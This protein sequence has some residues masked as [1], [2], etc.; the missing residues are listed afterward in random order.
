MD[1]GQLP[2][3]QDNSTTT[4]T[5]SRQRHQQHNGECDKQPIPGVETRIVA[6]AN[7]CTTCIFTWLKR[8]IFEMPPM[9]STVVNDDNLR[10]ITT[11]HKRW[12]KLGDNGA[13][14]VRM[15]HRTYSRILIDTVNLTHS[16]LLVMSFFEQSQGDFSS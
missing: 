12:G 3:T 10:T 2:A 11:T 1:D 4:S 13:S 14:M 9:T 6:R 7:M 8:S 5:V 16:H 15:A